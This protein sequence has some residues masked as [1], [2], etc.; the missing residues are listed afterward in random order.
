[1]NVKVIDELKQLEKEKKEMT[2]EE[3]LEKIEELKKKIEEMEEEDMVFNPYP[4]K[5]EDGY[6][7]EIDKYGLIDKLKNY[8][9]SSEHIYNTFNSE[10]YAELR[11]RE[12]DLQDRMWEFSYRHGW[13]DKRMLDENEERY[14]IRY[15]P[16][17]EECFTTRYQ[18]VIDN[19]VY[20][21][22]E[23]VTE[24]AIKKFGYELKELYELRANI[25][26][27]NSEND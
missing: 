7:Y 3:I 26:K 4:I 14:S 9:I 15:D 1:M 22:S 12:I 25:A 10:E 24:K 6:Y 17:Y 8:T 27:E 16:F 21:V 5:K 2:K 13:E 19:N 20:F 23:K 11:R 18:L